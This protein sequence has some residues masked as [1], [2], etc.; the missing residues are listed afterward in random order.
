MQQ[1]RQLLPDTQHVDG[2]VRANYSGRHAI[3]LNKT[4]QSGL[5]LHQ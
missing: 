5:K 1:W 4:A 2:M 3:V